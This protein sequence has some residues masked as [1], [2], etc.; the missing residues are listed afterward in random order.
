MRRYILSAAVIVF[1]TCTMAQ[2]ES[3][4]FKSK[5]GHVVLPEKGNWSIGISANPFL[6]YAG[7]FLNGAT[8]TN[9]APFVNHAN[10]AD[11]L[12]GNLNLGAGFLGKYMLEADMAVRVRFNASTYNETRKEW[13]AENSF[14]TNPL[15]PSFVEDKMERTLNNYNLSVGLEK[16]K[17]SSTRLQGIYG[18][19]VFI[20]Y[21]NETR[22]FDYGNQM[23]SDFASPAS[24]NFIGNVNNLAGVPFSRTTEQNVGGRFYVGARAFIGVEYFVAPKISLGAEMGYAAGFMT[25]GDASRTDETLSPET[26]TAVEVTTKLKRNQNLTG[27]G[28][29]L[30]NFNSNINLFFYF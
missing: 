4:G 2:N 27:F 14:I 8:A 15:T 7:N 18:A 24:F 16:R 29:G 12:N 9:A 20:G 10:A 6:Q 19:E 1:A 28:W 3:T 21:L 5:N 23:S 17:G 13:V 30:D 22:S 25:H 26:L 11:I